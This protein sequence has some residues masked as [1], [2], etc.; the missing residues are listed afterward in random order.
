MEATGES[1]RRVSDFGHDPAWS[2]D[3][4]DLLVSTEPIVDPMS[5]IGQSQLW[6]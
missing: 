4:R 2:H 5:R 3:G 1:V 6:R